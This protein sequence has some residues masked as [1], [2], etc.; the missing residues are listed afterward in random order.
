MGLISVYQYSFFCELFMF[1]ATFSHW[2]VDLFFPSPFV[3][4]EK[5]LG[6]GFKYV[7]LVCLWSLFIMCQT[8]AFLINFFT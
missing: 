4:R 5:S 6:Y 8:E 3:G 1:V 2:I 7:F